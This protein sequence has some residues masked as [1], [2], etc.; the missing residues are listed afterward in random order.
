MLSTGRD[1]NAGDAAM[2][3]VVS[4]LVY[5]SLPRASTD[6]LTDRRTTLVSP[7]AAPPF[8]ACMRL[9]LQTLCN[10]VCVERMTVFDCARL[11]AVVENAITVLPSPC[12]RQ[13][14]IHCM[15]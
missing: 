12:K 2:T 1:V 5:D 11:S 6:I 13:G 9:Y 3:L 14:H 10:T 8:K 4:D 15:L 7:Q